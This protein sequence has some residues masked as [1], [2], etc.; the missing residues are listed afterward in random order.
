MRRRRRRQGNRGRKPKAVFIG[1][2]PQA[3]VFTPQ[4]SSGKPP[5]LIEPA[6]LE[7]FRLVDMEGLS[8]EE[9]GE[10]MGV[11]R[12]TIWRLLQ[13]ARRKTAQAL[14]EG[15]RIQIPSEDT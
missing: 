6:E 7:A 9:A 11:S 12:G 10:R 14:T 4:P 8:Q 1:R 15:R 5:I 2:Q 13:E 3:D